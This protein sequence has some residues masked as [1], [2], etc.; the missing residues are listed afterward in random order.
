MNLKQIKNRIRWSLIVDRR[1]WLNK[2]LASVRQRRLR[3]TDF[4]II[5][6]NCWAGHVYRRYGL[7]YNTPT[8]GMYFFPDEYLRF[9][10]NLKVNVN[11]PMSFIPVEKSKH[12]KRLKELNQINVPIALLGDNIEIVM[13]H[14]HSEEEVLEKWNRRKQRINWDHLLVKNTQM[15]GMTG[16]QVKEF[17][18]LPFE[19]KIIFVPKK[20]DN[21]KSAIWYK[22]DCRD[23]QVMDDIINFNKYIDLTKWINSCY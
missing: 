22:T 21:I 1:E 12:Y 11:L 2:Y 6:N 17:D 16:T 9:V 15:N 7:N 13:L 10:S 5:S 18:E 23:G 8:V 4:T 20:M 3:G 19:H 14:Y